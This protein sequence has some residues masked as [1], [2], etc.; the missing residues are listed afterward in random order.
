MNFSI[1]L[2]T[3]FFLS[4]S[5]FYYS[6]FFEKVLQLSCFWKWKKRNSFS[7]LFFIS[8]TT[9]IPILF[10][11]TYISYTKYTAVFF[12]NTSI[13]C[14]IYSNNLLFSAFFC[15]C[16]PFYFCVSVPGYKHFSYCNLVI[17][18]YLG[19]L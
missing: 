10:S 2:V 13:K 19:I 4:H 14:A 17:F 18:I 6:L 15:C 3:I 8:Q 12:R 5:F 11:F 16:S 7:Y 1:P 9:L